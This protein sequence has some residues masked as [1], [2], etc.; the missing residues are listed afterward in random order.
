MEQT[1][2]EVQRV[3]K[4]KGIVSP[5]R[6]TIRLRILHISAKEKT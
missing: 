1:I 6:R 4:Q 2:R 3:A 5:S